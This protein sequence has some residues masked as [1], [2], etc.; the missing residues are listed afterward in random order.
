MTWTKTALSVAFLALVAVFFCG[1]ALA[2]SPVMPSPELVAAP[3]AKSNPN[4]RRSITLVDIGPGTAPE[5]QIAAQACAGLFNRK[6]GGSVYTR[7]KDKDGRW[8]EELGLKADEVMEAD[9]FVEACLAEFP[10]CVRYS[11]Q[12]QQKLLPNIL[13]AAAAFEAVPLDREMGAQCGEVAFD[14]LVEFKERNTPLLATRYAYENFVNETSGLAM[15]DPGYSHAEGNF[16]RDEIV[17]EMNPVMVDLVFSKKLF[18]M[19]LTDGCIDFSP[20]H[21]LLNEIVRDNPW[22]KPIGV[23]GYAFYWNVFG[24]FLFESQTM[25]SDARNM[26]AIPTMVNN[27]SFFSTRRAPISEPGELRQNAEEEIEYDPDKT[28]VAFIVGDGDNVSFMLGFRTQ[29]IEQ[30]VRACLADENSCPPLSWSISPQLT[31]LA[32][33]VLE[34]YY[35]MGRQTGKDHFMLPPSG[36]LYSYPSSLEAGEVQE[37]YIAATEN[38]ARLLGTE[39]VV[40]WEWFTDWRRTENELLPKYA[41]RDGAIRGVVAVNVPYLFPTFTWGRNQFFKV[42]VGP[43]AGQSVLFRPR[44]WR[45]ID[46]R[47][48]FGDKEYYLSPRNMAKELGGYPRGTVMAVYMT[49]DGGLTLENSVME[50]VKV[51]PPHVRL[52]SCGAAIRLVT[53]ASR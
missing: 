7:M 27:L 10:R 44:V 45:G 12:E 33:D 11:Y 31:S 5:L 25:C 48:K 26:G 35:G 16:L 49:S 52:V 3:S 37:N 51:L 17:A 42:L 28:Y 47:G 32:P 29:W 18:V 6:R 4:E 20:Q 23:Y 41:R 39:G 2:A 8:L 24:G 14:A 38:D 43:D 30:R 50:L 46:D 21:A 19:Y 1:P 15:L 9:R 36:H 22:P 40:H 53:Q 13:T 34:W